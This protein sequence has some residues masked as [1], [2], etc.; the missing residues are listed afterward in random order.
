MEALVDALVPAMPAP[1]RAAVTA[2]A[3]GIPLFAVETVRA[4]I[5]RDIVQPIEGVYRLVGEVGELA[6]PDSLHAL[7]AARLDALDPGVRRLV[8]D[9]A[10]LGTTFPA[11]AL[12]AVSGQDGTTVRAALDELVR[13]EVFTVSADPLSPEK[14]SYGSPSTCCAR[15]PTTPCPAATARPATWRW[16]RTC[17]PPSPA[18]AR[19]SPTSLPAT[20]STPWTRSP[21][22][23]TPRKSAARRS[24][25]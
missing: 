8:A 6:V 24:R 9:A 12:L 4:L 19:K 14:G 5:D 18:T 22:T 25:R 20:T 16:P 15:S 21:M 7:L 10:V 1:A 17:A 3:Q 23:A 2:Q 11:E 13:R